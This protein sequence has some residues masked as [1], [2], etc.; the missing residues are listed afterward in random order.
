M[1][2]AEAVR[3]GRTARARRRQL[4][5]RNTYT[6]ILFSGMTIECV[7]IAIVRVRFYIDSIAPIDQSLFFTCRYDK[8]VDI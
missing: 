2:R 3:V 4:C 6:Y 1:Y 5:L 7:H 8:M